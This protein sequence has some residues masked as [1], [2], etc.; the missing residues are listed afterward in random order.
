MMMATEPQDKIEQIL[1][2]LINLE[3]ITANTKYNAF[4][5]THAA[6]GVIKEEY[7]E[8]NNERKEI[9]KLIIQ[10][11]QQACINSKFIN[12]SDTLELL[13]LLEQR[14]INCIKELIQVIA[15]A[16]KAKKLHE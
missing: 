4:E 10:Y 9:K 7:Q 3:L 2:E 12:D 5:I 11:W 13:E 8:A 1:N 14:G 15:M 6:H 16:R